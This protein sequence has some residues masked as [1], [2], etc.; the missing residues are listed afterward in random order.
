MTPKKLRSRIFARLGRAGEE[1]VAL[2]GKT[3]KITGEMCVIADD[4]GAIGLGGV[5]GGEGTGCTEETTEVLIE[6]AYFDPLRTAQTGR[7]LGIES[8]ARYR[9][10]RGVD[11]AFVDPGLDLATKMILDLCGG[12]PSQSMRC[13]SRHRSTVCALDFN[14]AEIKRLTGVEL[15]LGETTRILTALGFEP[16]ASGAKLALK[17][18]TWRPDID[19][20]ADIVEEVVRI[21]GLDKVP[22][23]PMSRPP[24]SAGAILTPLQTALAHHTPG[25]G[26]ARACRSRHL[27]V[28]IA[29]P[30]GAFR[31]RQRIARAR[32]PDLE[33]D[34][35]DAPEP[36]CG[37]ACICT[38]Q[39][40]SGSCARLALSRSA[41]NSAAMRRPMKAS[42]A[43]LVR[44][45][46]AP[47]HWQKPA[48]IDSA[49]DAKADALALLAS[50]GAPR[51]LQTTDDAPPWYH[52]GRSGTLRL[53]PKVVLAHFGEL[54]P[55]VLKAFNIDGPVAAAEIFVENL[56]EVKAKPTKARGPLNASDL[57]AVKRDFAFLVDASAKAGEMVRAAKNVDKALIT[58]VSVFDVYEGE[59]IEA[60][61]KSIA[62]EVTLQPKD[63]TLTEEEIDA[64]SRKIVGAVEKVSG[65][66]LRS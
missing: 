1:L 9:F 26:G 27:V 38:A 52:P 58:D 45:G 14:P 39:C 13:W 59:R 19:G 10:E 24:A 61:K 20:N 46:P 56:P 55:R 25:V 41:S 35:Y 2:D 6:S 23:T 18:P 11:P 40:R 66:M 29:C 51:D 21:H 7:A 43:A 12:E 8:D 22:S 37:L 50:L 54:H 60:G 44:K 62:I 15:P 16:K 30:C 42:S 49:F 53:G 63:R 64:V 32:Q 34:G 17:A 4:G 28:H 47:R 33:R 31:R 57:M 48:R 36:A 65:G 3:Y 5:M